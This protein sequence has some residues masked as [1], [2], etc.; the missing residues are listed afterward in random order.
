MT[1]TWQDTIRVNVTLKSID[2]CACGVPFAM[3]ADLLGWFR[4]HEDRWFWCPNGH[5]QHFS[6]S[7]AT[8]LKRKLEEKEAALQRARAARDQYQGY[9]QGEQRS[10]SATKGQLTRARRRAAH[11]VC[12]VPECSR[13]P[14][15]N[16]ARHMSS[17][18]AGYV[19][20]ADRDAGVAAA[21]PGGVRVD[22]PYGSMRK[23]HGGQGQTAY[24]C[25]CGWHGYTSG[26]AAARHARTCPRAREPW[27]KGHP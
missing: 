7:E 19:A 25:A 1:M 6:E 20:D 11:G 4:E 18:H 26:G 16:L 23:R 17:K 10:H 8:R 14:F 21:E 3:P 2:C 5:Q 13:R 24:D 15:D 22:G 12:P 27:P 9:W